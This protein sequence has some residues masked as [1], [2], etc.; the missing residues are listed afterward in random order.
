MGKTESMILHLLQCIP[1]LKE[2]QM[3]RIRKRSGRLSTRAQ[4]GN[5]LVEVVQDKFIVT[6]DNYFTLPKV[7]AKL[8][9]KG[10]GIVGTSRFRK[11]WP[12]KE[13]KCIDGEK[14]QFNDFF[15]DD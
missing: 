1:S 12:P 10:I 13:L 9:E 14:V 8:R 4:R 2:K 6:M 3:K 7:I 5:E 15:L 11:N